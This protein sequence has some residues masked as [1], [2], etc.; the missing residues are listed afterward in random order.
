MDRS[1]TIKHTQKFLRVKLRVLFFIILGLLDKFTSSRVRNKMPNVIVFHEINENGSIHS[2]E[3]NTGLKQTYFTR[4]L[5]QLHKKDWARRNHLLLT[6]DDGYFLNDEIMEEL[7][8]SKLK[9]I[10]FVNTNTLFSGLRYETLLRYKDEILTDNLRRQIL[11]NK[12]LLC[13]WGDE[14][15]KDLSEELVESINAFQGRYFTSKEMREV[16]KASIVLGDHFIDHLDLAQL[17]DEDLVEGIIR[18]KRLF[19]EEGLVLTDTFAMPHG[20]LK[21]SQIKVLRRLGYQL[22]FGGSAFSI[23]RRKISVIPRVQVADNYHNFL[24]IRG[25]LFFNRL[26]YGLKQ[27]RISDISNR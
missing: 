16:A 15:I 22:I 19:F 23:V 10:L 20:S 18:S 13:D 21:P 25:E 14:E 17:R 2:N 8:S 26:V 5:N 6:F 27:F 24:A 9:V 1:S 7:V 3:T 12:P 11:K 4:L